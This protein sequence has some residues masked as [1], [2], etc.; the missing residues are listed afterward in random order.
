MYLFFYTFFTRVLL[1]FFFCTARSIGV[2]RRL[3]CFSGAGPTG[4]CYE[5]SNRFADW[6]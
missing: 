3:V 2:G 4:M 5:T 6:A 1:S